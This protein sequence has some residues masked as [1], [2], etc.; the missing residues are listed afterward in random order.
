MKFTQRARARLVDANFAEAPRAAPRSSL[1]PPCSFPSFRGRSL[2]L[3]LWLVVSHHWK[4]LATL[5]SRQPCQLQVFS[6][7]WSFWRLFARALVP[8]TSAPFRS[9]FSGCHRSSCFLFFSEMRCEL[10]ALFLGTWCST[11]NTNSTVVHASTMGL[12]ARNLKGMGGIW[13]VDSQKRGL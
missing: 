3:V 7:H 13:E 12:T 2:V 8:T 4:W 1:H 6:R 9:T 10:P 11:L 5:N